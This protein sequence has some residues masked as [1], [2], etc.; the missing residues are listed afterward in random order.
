MILGFLFAC[1]DGGDDTATPA[2][3]TVLGRDLPSA[4]LSI[5]GD[6]ADDLWLVGSDIGRG[7]YVLH[8]TASGWAEVD[9][10]TSGDLW[11]A[12]NDGADVWMVGAGGRV[13]RG[14]G[15]TFS[16]EVLDPEVTLFGIWGSSPSDV[17]TV[18]G[19][20]AKSSAAAAMWHYDGTAWSPAVLPE[21][22]T[23][24]LA[25][26]K[27]WGRS[28]SEVYVVGSDGLL[29]Q[30]AG[31]TWTVAP[32]PTSYPL[33]TVHGDADRAYAVGGEYS[34]VIA[35]QD[36]GSWTDDT[37]S[38]LPQMNGV[39]VR[40]GCDPVAVGTQGGQVF[41][42]TADGWVRDERPSPTPYDFHA[43][44]VSPDCDVLAV[45]GYLTAIPMSQGVVVWNG[46]DE[47]AELP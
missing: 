23:A 28:P 36:A 3:W 18:G 5:H 31:F 41:E 9:T 44:W 15:S 33:F 34:G 17:W 8:H 46:G 43:V 4:V 27:V 11:W 29:L 37:P 35:A 22:A 30:R 39:Y 40:E 42:R 45:G 38:G 6:D 20:I 13:V 24:A 26:Y 47:L 1:S 16:E 7:P 10:G 14:D 12:W 32:T 25:L 19:N 2:E 21:E